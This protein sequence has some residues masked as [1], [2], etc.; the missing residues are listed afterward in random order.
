MALSAPA[1]AGPAPGSLHPRLVLRIL[2][3]HRLDPAATQWTVH[4][5]GGNI[6]S[7]LGTGQ[8]RPFR[9]EGGRLILSGSY[10]AEGRTIRYERIPVR[11]R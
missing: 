2:S 3:P 4:V 7:F 1:L 10:E 5:E 6:P 9:I 11:A 8:T